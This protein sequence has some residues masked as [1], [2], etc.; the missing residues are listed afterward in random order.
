MV[1]SSGASALPASILTQTTPLTSLADAN[2]YS[3]PRSIHRTVKPAQL[4]IWV[5][6]NRVSDL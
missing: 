4:G 1:Y 5:T 6:S 2:R 3:E